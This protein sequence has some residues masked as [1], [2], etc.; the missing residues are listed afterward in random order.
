MY[1][2][3]RLP[4]S[5]CVRNCINTVSLMH[6]FQYSFPSSQTIFL[7]PLPKLKNEISIKYWAYNLKRV[8]VKKIK[9]LK[10][11]P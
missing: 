10:V 7:C 5:S 6:C 3:A 9:I 4:M 1:C 2:A 8:F 11:I